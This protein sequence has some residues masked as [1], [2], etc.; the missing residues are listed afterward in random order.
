MCT[1]T[2]S[3]IKDYPKTWKLKNEHLLSHSFC[4]SGVAAMVLWP[5][6]LTGYCQGTRP[7]LTCGRTYSVLTYVAADQ[8]LV[9]T[10]VE[11]R[12]QF[13]VMW[14]LEGY[15]QPS[16][17]HSQSKD[18]KTEWEMVSKKEVM[19]ISEPKLLKW[20]PVTFVVFCSLEANHWIHPTLRRGNYTK[21]R[22][23]GSKDHWGHCR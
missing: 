3:C 23:P 12:H 21:A 16:I 11:W 13:L 9:L 5:V 14:A 20:Y 7:K 6:S 18:S 4:V 22:T 8:L 17:L 1:S 10:D 15:S 19:V 2:D